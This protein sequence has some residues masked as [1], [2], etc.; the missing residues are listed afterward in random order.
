VEKHAK[1]YQVSIHDFLS[2]ADIMVDMTKSRYALVWEI[3]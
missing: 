3:T 2:N 1:T